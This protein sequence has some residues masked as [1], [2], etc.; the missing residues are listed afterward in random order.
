MLLIR[1]LLAIAVGYGRMLCV[2]CCS[3]S[4]M[5]DA[6]GGD[7]VKDEPSDVKQ[8]VDVVTAADSDGTL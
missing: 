2:W 8:N 7:G 1:R 6:D 4:D 5:R 3:V